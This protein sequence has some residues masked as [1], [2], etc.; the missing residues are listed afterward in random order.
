MAFEDLETIL[1]K[2]GIVFLNYGGYLTQ[3]LISSMTNA[4]ELEA[5]SKDISMKISGHIFTI[6]IELSQNMM[7]YAK[8][9]QGYEKSLASKGL[10]V[11][12]MEE[13]EN[14]FYILS[15]NIIDADDK[16]VVE[17]RLLEIEGLSKEELRELYRKRRKEGKEKHDKGAGIGLIEI[18]KRCDEIEHS[19]QPVGD[20]Q[21]FFT[22]KTS[23]YRN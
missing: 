20:N 13:D 16:D 17:A 1:Q 18:A 12:G 9:K 4:L 11:V 5:E 19:F 10:I 23:I 7:N 8:S 22:L 21:Y 6:F 15:R 2:N 3:S 14:K